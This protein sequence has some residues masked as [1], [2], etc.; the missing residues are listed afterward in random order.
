MGSFNEGE[1]MRLFKAWRS[2]SKVL[3]PMP[4]FAVVRAFIGGCCPGVLKD[5]VLALAEV[6][7]SN[8]MIEAWWRSLRHNW[9]YLHR[10]DDIA[11]VRKLVAFYVEQHNEVMPHPAFRGQTPSEMYF[12]TGSSIPM[13]VEAAAKGAQKRRLTA[14]RAAR[15]YR[16]VPE[17]VPL[18]PST[19]GED[20]LRFP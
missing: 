15:C 5:R 8:S 16:C 14:N 13:E 12:G 19:A 9:L 18:L 11:E 10:L 7:Y 6:S 1:E 2:A 3:K 4:L 17:D 20:D